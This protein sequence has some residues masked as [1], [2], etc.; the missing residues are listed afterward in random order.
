MKKAVIANRIALTSTPELLE[1][2]KKTL[3]YRLPG[4]Q[5]KDPPITLKTYSRYADK[6]IFIPSGRTD[7]IPNE[8]EIIDKRVEIPTEFPDFKFTLRDDQ[9]KIYDLVDDSCLI[10]ANVSWG[11]TFTSIA[12]AKKLGQKTL[13]IVDKA[14]LRKQWVKEIKKTLGIEPGIIGGGK[15]DYKNTPITV[16]TIQT[17]VNNIKE[18]REEFGTVILDEAHHA[19]AST[20]KKCLNL[21]HARYKIGLSATFRRKDQQHIYIR[22]YFSATNFHVA[23]RNNQLEPEILMVDTGISFNSNP[24]I[25]WSKKLNQLYNDPDYFDIVVST[26]EGAA[27]NGHT[28][29]LVCDRIDFLE[30]CNEALGERSLLV[31]GTYPKTD[32]EREEAH[33]QIL[34]GEKKI[35]CG[36]ISIYK[37]GISL[38]TLSCLALACPI[39]NEPLLE[40][41]IGRIQRIADDKLTPLVIDYI[42]HGVTGTKQAKTRGVHYV[43]NGYKVTHVGS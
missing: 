38:N 12:V 30:R 35:L 15:L 37:E 16:G 11:K 25:H 20:F 39:N 18:L 42:L 19:P 3:T 32:E 2:V 40:Q 33:Q 23:E 34:S 1:K 17:I 28:V 4:K 8:Y 43:H 27:D 5:P 41:L 10:N 14:N 7:L 6:V 36:T 9:Q 13:V 29:L 22:D 21:F 24:Y 31:T 26:V